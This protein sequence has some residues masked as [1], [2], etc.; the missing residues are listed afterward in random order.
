MGMIVLGIFMIVL[1]LYDYKNP[2]S[3]L[4]KFLPTC[5]QE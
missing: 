1:G 5:S 2:N 3:K 4:L